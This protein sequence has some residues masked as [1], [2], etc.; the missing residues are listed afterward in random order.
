MYLAAWLRLL[1]RNRFA[2]SPERIPRALGITVLAAINSLLRCWQKLRYGRRLRRVIVP[3]DPLFIIG[4]WRTGTTMLHELLA[5]DH[6]NR[7]P[8]NYE[9]LSPNHF[10]VS[11]PFARRWLR[12][13][14]PRK[15]PFD[16]VRLGFDRPQ[17]DEVALCNLGAPSPFLTVAFPNRPP[18]YPAYVDLDNLSPRQLQSWRDTMRRFLQ[19]LL[20]RRAG[21]LVLKSP[22]HTFRVRALLEMFPRARFVHI[23]RDPYVVFPSTVHFWR[24]MYTSYAL[25]TPKCDTLERQVF[26]T[27]RAMHDSLEAARPLVDSSRFFELRYEDLVADPVSQM[28]ALYAHLD[29]GDF[30]LV[31]PAVAAYAIRSKRYRTNQ[32]EVSQA[33]RRQITQ[34]W[35][36][37]IAKYAYGC[38]PPHAAMRRQGDP[39]M[40][41]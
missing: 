14:I 2:I 23:V 36:R 39:S 6:R 12:F 27:F 4:H 11:E 3:D 33:T 40:R 26:E 18:Q 1:A 31:E 20:F 38:D 8:T 5:L 35:S 37:C 34:A 21:R 30:S 29:L 41:A 13:L 32:Y 19:S 15:R 28:R 10:L 17:E 25:Q 7:C 9:C 24:V 22:Q 16:Q